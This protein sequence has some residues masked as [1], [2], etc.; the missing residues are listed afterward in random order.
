MET[1]VIMNF[2]INL[3]NRAKCRKS[4]GDQKVRERGI[5]FFSKTAVAYY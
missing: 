3:H 1:T 2:N 4:T 5:R